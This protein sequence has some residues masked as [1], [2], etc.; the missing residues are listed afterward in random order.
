MQLLGSSSLMALPAE[1]DFEAAIGPDVEKYLATDS[2]TG[3]QRARIFHLAWDVAC[4]SF[5]GRQVLY[6][7]S[8]SAAI[9]VRNAMMAYQSYNKDA[10]VQ[11]VLDFLDR[12]E[13]Q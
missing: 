12:E 2:A 7:R 13:Q 8:S 5:G 9:P 1:K 3:W 6:E 11:R 10:A 4:S